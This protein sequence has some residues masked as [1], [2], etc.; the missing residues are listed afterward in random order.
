MGIEPSA[1]RPAVV[2]LGGR[3]IDA[4][5]TDPPRFPLQNVP[6]VRKRVAEALVAERAVALVCSAACGADL[7]ALEEA[8]RLGLRRR[9]VLPFAPERFRVSSVV[10]RPGEWGPVYDHLITAATATRDLVVLGAADSG[11]DVAYARANE[12]II[13]EARELAAC[14]QEDGPYRLL[15]ILVWEGRARPGTDAT[16]GFRRLALAAG[17]ETSSVLTR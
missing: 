6:L 8:E 1:S 14:S 17:F 4:A 2:A 7:I 12:A 3:R 13:R 5:G 16:E 9:I 15:A 11:D 10:D